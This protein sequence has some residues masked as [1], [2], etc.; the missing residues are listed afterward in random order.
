MTNV[1]K[2]MNNDAW[3]VTDRDTALSVIFPASASVCTHTLVCLWLLNV[4]PEIVQDAIIKDE[5]IEK[6]GKDKTGADKAARDNKDK[7]EGKGLL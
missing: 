7:K 5:K 2:Y 4:I 1:L 6:E 3:F